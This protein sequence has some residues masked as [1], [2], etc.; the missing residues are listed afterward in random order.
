M[1]VDIRMTICLYDGTMRTEGYQVLFDSLVDEWGD[2]RSVNRPNLFSFGARELL[3]IKGTEYR[4]RDCTYMLGDNENNQ[5][6]RRIHV[7]FIVEA[8]PLP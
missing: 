5:F 1:A 2:V 6:T 8:A 4:F 7:Q 3:N